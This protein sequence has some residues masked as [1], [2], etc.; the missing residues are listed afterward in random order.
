MH[1]PGYA[2]FYP[3]AKPSDKYFVGS[4]KD[5]YPKDKNGF[6]ASCFQYGPTNAWAS[7]FRNKS[8]SALP[9][10]LISGNSQLD[11]QIVSPGNVRRLVLDLIV[12]NTGG[13]TININPFYCIDRFDIYASDGSVCSQIYGETLYQQA[14]LLF[15]YDESTRLLPAAGIDMSTWNGVPIAAGAS[16]EFLIP[17]TCFT[18]SA[19][20]RFSALNQ[21]FR[22][23]GYFTSTN[24]GCDNAASTSVIQCDVW[25]YGSVWDQNIE[26]YQNNML[27]NSISRYIYQQP[28]RCLVQTTSNMQPSTKY[29][30]QI[31]SMTG[32]FSSL[33]FFLQSSPISYAN[34][35]IYQKIALIE[36]DDSSNTIIGQQLIPEIAQ[37]YQSLQFP[38]YI[39]N[40]V[41]GLQNLY[42]MNFN[43]GDSNLVQLQGCQCGLYQANRNHDRLSLIKI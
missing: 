37:T 1:N 31:S 27:K 39:L 20:F 22:F 28:V 40:Q 25:S 35:K 11:Y 4:N 15:N 43:I 30:F 29:Q 13:S 23:R 26:A 14:T 17:L 19:K 33:V 6:P 5:I 3:N 2:T 24:G 8:F 38:G 42:V 18:D 34:N 9:S 16:A 7:W 21:P 10:S 41:N 32:L 12:S 36:L